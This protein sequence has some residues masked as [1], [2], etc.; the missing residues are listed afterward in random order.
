MS[1]L[2]LQNDN[3]KV[4]KQKLKLNSDLENL[5]SFSVIYVY[6]FIGLLR[7]VTEINQKHRINLTVTLIQLNFREYNQNQHLSVSSLIR[8]LKNCKELY[9]VYNSVFINL[10]TTI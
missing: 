8:C 7:E 9:Q 6:R 2:E 1:D 3:T 5:I 4:G 10:C